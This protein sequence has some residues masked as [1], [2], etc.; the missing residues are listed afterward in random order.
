MRT[1]GR[2]TL[3]ALPSQAIV[4]AKA[5]LKQPKKMLEKAL[6]NE[7]IVNFSGWR[8]SCC[9]AC[10]ESTAKA[11]TWL[12]RPSPRRVSMEYDWKGRP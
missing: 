11:A 6:Q 8:S 3:K 7:W 9:D 1:R 10:R 5:G 2:A 12:T 4:L